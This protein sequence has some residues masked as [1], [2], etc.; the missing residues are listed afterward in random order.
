MT[1]IT[2]D[3]TLLEQ[4]L[5]ALSSLFSWKQDDERP[6]RVHNAI[7]ELSAALAAPRIEPWTSLHLGKFAIGLHAGELTITHDSG[8]GGQFDAVKFEKHVAK[9]FRENF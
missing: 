1:R 5:E 6:L 2:V 8:E 9:F 7:R 4:A 3:R